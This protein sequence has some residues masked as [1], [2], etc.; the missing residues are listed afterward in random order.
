MKYLATAI[1]LATTALSPADPEAIF[2]GKTLAGWEAKGPA[3]WT[4]GDGIL[5]GENDPKKKGSVLW[6][7]KE[8]EDFVFECE[9]RFNGKIDSGVFLRREH[10][11]IQIGISGS[12]QRDMTASPYI[13]GKGYPVEAE[14]VA[15]LLKEGDWN[16]M[17]ITAVG[18]RYTVEL[19]GKKVMEY[20]SDTSIDKGPIGFQIHS[21]RE[22][23]IEF[24]DITL[25]EL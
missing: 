2:D 6:T 4:A 23:K 17:K 8:Y 12:L 20:E 14:G 1:L 22:M 25:E 3:P 21:G 16:R 5:T 18:N 15:D 11:Q 24:R 7:K 19:N 9:F 13:P 10:D